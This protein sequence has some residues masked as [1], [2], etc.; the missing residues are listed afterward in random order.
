MRFKSTKNRVT[1]YCP[2]KLLDIVYEELE[3]NL[4]LQGFDRLRE[5]ISEEWFAESSIREGGEK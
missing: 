1:I 5:V 2:Q 4:R 3:L